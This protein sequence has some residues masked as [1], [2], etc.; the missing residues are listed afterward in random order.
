MKFFA[1][2][3]SAFVVVVLVSFL[4]P[5]VRINNFAATQVLGS[6]EKAGYNIIP[7]LSLTS[8]YPTFSAS[9]VYAFDINSG[10]SL[11][12]KNPSLKVLPAST[13][14][15]ITSLVALD[16]YAM[17]EV[18]TVKSPNVEGQKMGLVVGEKIK[19][20]DLL[21]GLLLYSANDAAEELA[22]NYPGGKTVFIEEMNKKAI[23]IGMLNSNFQNPQGYEDPSHISTAEDM[24][25]AGAF[26]LNDDTFSKIVST[27]EYQA[28]SIDGIYKHKMTNIN[29]LLGNVPGV[30]GIKTGWTE[31]A[32]EN[33]V[34]YISRDGHDV[35]ISV[36]GSD[37]RFGE[38]K[39]IIDWIFE[40]YSWMAVPESYGFQT[41]R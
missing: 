38:S 30:L 9:S 29:T 32:K 25:I 19:V 23:E 18:V 8:T 17:E 13:T 34:T 35:V 3:I 37:D 33:L 26:A 31:N 24:A 41:A 6:T 11:Y 28:T 4:V 36:L 2:S 7:I 5:P 39:K 14:K 27:R 21:Y 20:I 10:V 40:S 12:E 22:L 16:Y 1:F 15:I